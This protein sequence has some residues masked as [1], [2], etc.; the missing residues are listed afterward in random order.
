M[1]DT[2][3]IE[4]VAASLRMQVEGA[5]DTEDWIR[6]AGNLRSLCFWAASVAC[7]KCGGQGERS[8]A[9]T[10]TWRGGIG[11]HA[12]TE[13]VCD[14]CWGSGRSDQPWADLR[15]LETR[16]RAAE[17][18]KGADESARWLAR[19]I[20]AGFEHN[21]TRLAEVAAKLRGMRSFGFWTGQTRDALADALEE[22]ANG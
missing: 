6:A 16:V 5:I 17:T 18:A 11:G 12:M 10:A 9:S 21:R 20:G 15:A 13:D 4:E 8:Y 3:T 1:A 22:I 2:P 14:S 19:R 7:E